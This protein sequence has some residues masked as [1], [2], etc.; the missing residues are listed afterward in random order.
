MRSMIDFLSQP[1]DKKEPKNNSIDLLSQ[2]IDKKSQI[3]K[4]TT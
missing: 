2:P 1:I 3:D 4:K